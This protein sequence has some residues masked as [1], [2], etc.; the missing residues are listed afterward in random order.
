MTDFGRDTSCLPGTGLR[1]GRLVSGPRLVAEAGV[2][3]LTTRR[4]TLRGGE[5]EANYGKDLTELVG[6]VGTTNAAAALPGQIK[7]ELSKDERIDP[8]KISVTV[9]STVS[10]PSTKWNVAVK[11]ETAEGPFDFVL[12]VSDVSVE[13]LGM[14]PLT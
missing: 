3:R 8:G 5:E 11:G 2:R 14:N 1:T 9:T 10:G 6:T 7:A 12:A 4:G 13:L